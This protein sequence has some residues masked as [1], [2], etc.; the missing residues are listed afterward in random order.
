MNNTFFTFKQYL[1][2]SVVD[3]PK[4]SL[5]PTVFSF[6]EDSPPV[7]QSAIKKQIMRDIERI[8]N[9]YPVDNYYII[10]S[11]LTKRYNPN[12]DIDVCVELEP[13]A[14]GQVTN[15]EL[16]RVAKVVNGKLATGTT[17]KI[18]YRLMQHQYDLD[19]TDAAYDIKNE[20]WIK[21][22][23][24]D[25]HDIE[26]YA[27]MFE[28]AIS[29]VDLLTG[30]LRRDIIDLNSYRAMPTSKI[31]K[32][33]SLIEKKLKEIEDDIINLS[34]SHSEMSYLR[35]LAFERDLTQDELSKY[36]SHNWLPENV[37]YKLYGKYHY[38]K[39]IEKLKDFLDEK[40]KLDIK[41]VPYI[42]KLGSQLWQK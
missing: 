30:E 26:N 42:Q 6:P 4:N 23:K 8:S 16:I 35:K 39:F 38:T 41:D 27:S 36:S 40:Q 18:N 34:N 3:I 25:D 31:K 22:E 17:H 1:S 24:N 13:S 12:S 9:V 29:N 10:G 11:I 37:I 32:L 5:D 15:N 28:S 14:N 20:K 21:K 19:K 7:L 33:K 2:E